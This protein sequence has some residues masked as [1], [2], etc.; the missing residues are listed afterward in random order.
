MLCIERS[1]REAQRPIEATIGAIGSDQKG[2]GRQR[3][4]RDDYGRRDARC[5]PLSVRNKLGIDHI[6][7]DLCELVG[8]DRSLALLVEIGRLSE[9]RASAIRLRT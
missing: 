6:C 1:D 4:D 7:A 9:Q 3:V 2:N 5:K 8:H